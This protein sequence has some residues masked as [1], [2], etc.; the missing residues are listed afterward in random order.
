MTDSLFPSGEFDMDGQTRIGGSAPGH[1]TDEEDSEQSCHP[2]KA[3]CLDDRCY[4]S[5]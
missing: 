2:P 3:A 4:H 5:R 1:V